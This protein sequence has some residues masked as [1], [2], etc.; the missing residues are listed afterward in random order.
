MENPP[1]RRVRISYGLFV[2]PLLLGSALHAQQTTY[3]LRN[4][5]RNP[6][7]GAVKIPLSEVINFDAGPYGR[8][9]H[10]L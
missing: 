5:A 8:T 3:D 1:V 4:L 7:G 10:S 9:A 2:V 6:V